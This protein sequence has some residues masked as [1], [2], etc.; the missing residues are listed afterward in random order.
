VNFGRNRVDEDDI[1]KGLSAY[2]SDVVT[3]I[4]LEIRDVH[5]WSS[6]LLYIF[7]GE[8]RKLKLSLINEL[9]RNNINDSANENAVL[10]LLLWHG[11][12]GLVRSEH[13]V[14]YIYDVNY[15]LRRLT[16]LI[17]KTNGGDPLMQ[18]NPAL[19]PGL[20]MK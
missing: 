1:V 19:W 18:I 11:V 12:I 10:R 13:D 6:D 15:D 20:E 14:T 9:M 5:S 8:C 7:L 4:D 3:E 16:G 17:G 2:S